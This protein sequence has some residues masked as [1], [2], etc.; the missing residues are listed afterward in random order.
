[1]TVHY[2]S[3]PT[4]VSTSSIVMIAAFLAVSPRLPW[5][6]IAARYEARAEVHDNAANDV[7]TPQKSESAQFLAPSALSEIRAYAEHHVGT[8]TAVAGSF[9][10][11][12]QWSADWHLQ[13]LDVEHDGEVIR[14]YH[15]TDIHDPHHRFITMWNGA[16][17]VWEAR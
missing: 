10:D 12:D 5:S 4:V 9:G 8:H 14:I 2:K 7:A 1:M 15:A 13:W 16:Q 6:G 3:L 17:A 11:T